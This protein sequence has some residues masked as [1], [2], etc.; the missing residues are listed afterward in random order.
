[1]PDLRDDTTDDGFHEIQFS[2][3]QLVFLFMA[4]SAILISVFIFGVLVG[5]DTTTRPPEEPI[6]ANVP[7][8]VEPSPT[9]PGNEPKTP[10]EEPQAAPG[11]D[12]LRYPDDLGGKPNP[13]AVN[14]PPA[15][16]PPVAAPEPRPEAP[17][18]TPEPETPKPT[19]PDTPKPKPTPPPTAKPANAGPNVPT[20][21]KP[22]QW[23]L[24]VSALKTR[25]A[26]AESVQRLINKGYDAYL[27]DTAKGLYRVRIG[28]FKDREDALRVARRYEKEEGTKLAVQR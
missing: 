13:S 25:Q 19:Q 8:Q 3:K 20:S 1:V 12:R 10:T 16:Q 18:P 5:R 17:T 4:A 2:S 27:E 6:A 7:P 22:G 24:Q 15:T 11:G 23:V 26:A 14:P 28:K 21:G 9:A